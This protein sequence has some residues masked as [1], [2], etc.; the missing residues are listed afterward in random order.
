MTD[1]GFGPHATMALYGEH[2][3]RVTPWYPVDTYY[4][5]EPHTTGV[6]IRWV[7]VRPW[8]LLPVTK[9]FDVAITLTGGRC[10]IAWP[11]LRK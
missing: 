10:T 5:G 11:E 4:P 9:W 7:G 8:R 1:H 6:T 3:N 2:R